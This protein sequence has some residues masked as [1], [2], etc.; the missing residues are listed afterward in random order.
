MTNPHSNFA[1]DLA[2]YLRDEDHEIAPADKPD[3][4]QLSNSDQQW[5]SLDLTPVKLDSLEPTAKGYFLGIES[6]HDLIDAYQQARSAMPFEHD[7]AQAMSH[8]AAYAD[9]FMTDLFKQA[10]T[11]TNLQAKL[12]ASWVKE[13]D[14]YTAVKAVESLLN[15]KADLALLKI[16]Q[17]RNWQVHF[18]HI[19]IRCGSQ[20]NKDAE[21][22]V[23]MLVEQHAYKACQIKSEQ[24]YSF[25]DGW[26]AYML[27]K[28]LDNGQMIRLFIDQSDR[29]HPKQIIQ[30]WNHVYGYTAHH[31]AIRVTHNIHNTRQAIGLSEVSEA[32]QQQGVS[33]LT[34]TGQYTHGLL[35]QVFTRPEQNKRTPDSLMK[36]IA[37]IDAQL[38]NIIP[39]GKLLEIVSR[40]ELPEIF[41]GRFFALYNLD[42]HRDSPLHSVPCYQYFLPAQAAHV[43]KTSV[44]I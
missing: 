28:I 36:K 31:M 34:A 35:E 6:I 8:V 41:K 24:Y 18:D 27:Y 38:C 42:Y 37:K 10:R 11:Y 30:H 23:S 9:Q 7:L 39:N 5:V 21:R 22:I 29:Q 25:P 44:Q 14:I 17:E 33:I 40:K 13:F 32:L 3:C 26:N 12:I 1:I 19:A 20:K 43:I 15:S 4:I 2:Q 16:A